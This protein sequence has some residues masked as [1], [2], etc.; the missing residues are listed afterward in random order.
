MMRFRL[1]AVMFIAATAACS[2][3]DLYTISGHGPGGPDRTSFAGTVCTPLA[4]GDVFPVKIIYAIQGGQNV[5]RDFVSVV[6]DSLNQPPTLP[7]LK[8][9]LIAFHTVA[10]GLQ[11]SFVDAS[12]LQAAA[13]RYNA[14][15]ESGPVSLRSAL[16]LAKTFLSGDMV[17][18]CK[19]TV[20]R[21]R[22]VVFLIMLSEDLSCS[23][24]VY[25]P[26][27]DPRCN[28]LL[29][30]QQACSVCELQ[31]VS[32]DIKALS[33]IYG[34]GQVDVQPVY[35]VTTSN[36][37]ASAQAAAIA[38]GGGTSVVA[39]TPNNF[40]ST[41]QALNYTSLQRALVLKRV[42]AFNRSAISRGGQLLVDTDGDGLPD[43][44]EIA[45][46][47]D[48]TNPDTDGDG[49]S[50]GVEVRMGMDP[51]HPDVVNGCSPFIDSD[52]DR[53]NDCEERVLG[54]DPCQSDTD[55]DG[56]N[57]LVEFL[58]NTNP[59]V[60]EGLSDSD[61]D[62][63]I[64][65]DELVAHTDANSADLSY[66]TERGYQYT[67]QDATPTADGRPCYDIRA[68]NISLVST[69]ARKNQPLPD[70][71]KGT[72][73]I[74]LY[75]QFGRPDDPRSLGISSLRVQ[76]VQ[77]TPPNTKKPAGTIPIAS[78]DFILGN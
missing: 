49:I 40:Q 73:D 46:G 33:D 5:P 25:N 26:G 56:V 7:G 63:H 66:Y 6:V 2:N 9:E 21:T 3:A 78:D 52:G 65:L 37:L 59:V 43:Q 4:S 14:Y 54:T 71:P 12:G 47:T 58:S 10:T 19:A 32:G 16:R 61:R 38:L 60:P 22:Y 15:Q 28:A 72:N 42:I 44:D 18:T 62:G 23:Y 76:Q 45:L 31:K 29:P 50:D 69:L 70:I 74:Y 30:D 1:L 55:A 64:N 39:T 36:P 67:I 20:A 17:T 57:D 8:F 35:V 41:F 27:I 48:P 77:F 75:L 13:I 53:L 34:A 51:L 11:G 24:P 68:D